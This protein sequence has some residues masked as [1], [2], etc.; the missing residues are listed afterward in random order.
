MENETQPREQAQNAPKKKEWYKSKWGLVV[1]IIFFPY[2][3]IWY[4]W[5]KTKWNKTAKLIITIV[6]VIINIVALG[7]NSSNKT[8]ALNNQTT[9]IAT[10]DQQKIASLLKDAEKYISAENINEALAAIEE[11]KKLD[12]KNTDAI[13]LYNS[14]KKLDGESE[15]KNI[16]IRMSDEDFDLLKKNELTTKFIVNDKLNELFIVKLQENADSRSDYIAE[17]E[18]LKMKKEEEA[19]KKKQEVEA[20]EI[21]KEIEKQFSA[22]DGSHIK[23]SRLIKESMNDPDSY[24]HVE[25]KYGNMDDHLVVI[26]TFRGK[27]A[28]GGVVKNTVKASVSLDGED[29][30]ILEQY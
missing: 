1:A 10:E 22:W 4:M 9:K 21:K 12:A 17:A 26:T 16:L 15:V 2:F 30:E 25:T 13:S 28:F 27:N 14:T 24:E 3:L 6:F 20:E 19:E 5:T 23:L 18:A 7:D 11:A 29:I 8:P